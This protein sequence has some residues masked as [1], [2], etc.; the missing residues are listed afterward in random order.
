MCSKSFETI[1]KV[2][3]HIWCRCRPLW[4]VCWMFYCYYY[5]F[6][7]WNRFLLF[8]NFDELVSIGWNFTRK[9]E[10]HWTI[11]YVV[12]LSKFSTLSAADDMMMSEAA[13]KIQQLKTSSHVFCSFI[14]LRIS[15]SHWKI[16][17]NDIWRTRSHTLLNCHNI[18]IKVNMRFSYSKYVFNVNAENVCYRTIERSTFNT[19][20]RAHR[21]YN[22]YF[23][24][25]QTDTRVRSASSVWWM[26]TEAFDDQWT[27]KKFDTHK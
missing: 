12:N 13:L 21:P 15:V 6:V 10:Q 14:A 7:L 2:S 27:H 4:D 5:F 3:R 9:N 16:Y 11:K 20:K 19:Q 1:W 23:V 8:T 25:K 24:H 26:Q 18:L 17:I 22:L